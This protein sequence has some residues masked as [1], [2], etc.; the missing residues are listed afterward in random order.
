MFGGSPCPDELG[1]FLVSEGVPLVGH[2]GLSVFLPYVCL[3]LNLWYAGQPR[4]VSS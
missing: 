4:W 2:Y 1:D 3:V